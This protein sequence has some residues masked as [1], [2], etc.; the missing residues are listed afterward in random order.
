MERYNYN[1]AMREDIR[2]YCKD[3][4]TMRAET[5]NALKDSL[6]EL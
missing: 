4:D 2:A 1:E 6:Q 3:F 5:I